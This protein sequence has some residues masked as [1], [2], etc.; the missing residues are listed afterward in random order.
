MADA[1]PP[2]TD[3]GEG[4]PKVS[5]RAAEKEAKKLAA[6]AKK[7]ASKVTGAVTGGGSQ[8]KEP[9]DPFKSGWLKGVYSEKPVKEVHTRFPP[10]PNGYLHIG[11]AKA[12]TVN[13]GFARSYGGLCN[14][15][16]DDTNPAKE[17]EQFF[18]SIRQMVEWLGF[19]PARITY[20]SDDFDRLY[21]L[22]EELI[23]RGKAYVCHCSQADVK[24]GR[25][26]REDKTRGPRSVC[27]DW[28]R[29]ANENLEQFRGMRDG[30][31][32]AG[33]AHLRMKQFLGTKPEEY[34]IKEGDTAEVKKAKTKLKALADNPALWDVAAYRVKKPEDSHHHRTGDKWRIYPTYEFTHCLCDSFEDI[35]HSLCTTEFE[36]LRPAYNWLLEAL[37]HKLPDSDEKGPMQREYGRLNVEGT[38]LSKRRI[39][40]LVNGFTVG[41]DK[42]KAG[43]DE[44][45]ADGVAAI[46]LEEEGEAEPAPSKSAPAGSAGRK[47]PS[48]VR[49]WDD[50]RLFTL[51]ALRRRGVPPG[52]LKK[53]V[54][55]QGVTKANSNTMTHN[56]DA[57]IRAYLERTVPRLMLVLDPIPVTIENL[58]DDYL[59]ER[60][61]P[62]DPKDK[63]KGTHKVPFTKTIYID[64][65]DFRTEADPD[66]FRLAPGTSVGL[67]N[68]E[69]PILCKSFTTDSATGKVNAITA[70]YGA[71]VP[72][73]KAR[74]HWVGHSP[75]KH[76]S[77]VK[78]EVRFYNPLF[79]TSKPNE[80]DWDGG[81]YY[82]NVNPDSEIV[83]PNAMIECGFSHI[84]QNAPWPK[85]E[86]EA[87][88]VVDKSS[89]RFQGLRTGFFA[90]D[91][92]SGA[93]GE[94]EGKVVLNR[95]VSLKEDTGKK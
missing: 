82:D 48:V 28:S 88:G 17:E 67:L 81:G 74:I 80:L 6:K 65:D 83:Y 12:I 43:S 27:Q 90:L 60:E 62:F 44:E 47:I 3:G 69:H 5:K 45:V 7:E 51:V 85:E 54:L 93:E 92:E 31:Y 26:L 61:V 70:T 63:E 14:L 94:R 32:E 8:S 25:G 52:A 2:A 59:E 4:E 29:S 75:A 76:S 77:P 20:S 19:E 21:E 22:A 15:R 24:K 36:T 49:N 46:E 35:S 1:K 56:L 33:T 87:K 58:P 16:Y 9:T 71:D 40:K 84:R 78:A 18:T 30:K 50:P 66:F 37:D 34:E 91:K 38:I 39:E 72:A 95:I 86:G 23:R 53:F 11:H 13:F 57:T 68:V 41:D 73:G 55:D 79:R 64:A 89:V 42:K 10:E